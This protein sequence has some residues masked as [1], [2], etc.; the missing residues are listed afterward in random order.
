[1][2]ESI[3]LAFCQ[4]PRGQGAQG[5]LVTLSYF[6]EPIACHPRLTH[7]WPWPSARSA[8]WNRNVNECG[9][10]VNWDKVQRQDDKMRERGGGRRNG[11][12]RYWFE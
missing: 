7:L 2:L 9:M 10:A 4:H 5:D 6:L 1:M 11:T 12:P 8:W 3:K